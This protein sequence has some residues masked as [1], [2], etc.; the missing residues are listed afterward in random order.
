MQAGM[1][2]LGVPIIPGDPVIDAVVKLP[3]LPLIWESLLLMG[4]F[5]LGAPLL[6]V[7]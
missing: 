4:S 7:L 3:R 5:H 6:K 1:Q 2:C